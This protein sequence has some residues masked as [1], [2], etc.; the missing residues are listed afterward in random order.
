MDRP[1]KLTSAGIDAFLDH[2]TKISVFDKS[3]LYNVKDFLSSQGDI[4][5]SEENRLIQLNP[6]PN[7][8]FKFVDNYFPTY[9]TKEYA[10]NNLGV[11][12]S[13]GHA[14]FWSKEVSPTLAFL[15]G[16]YATGAGT[17]AL[18]L[19]SRAVQLGVNVN[20]TINNA[21]K[22]IDATISLQSNIGV[23][24]SAEDVTLNQ[25]NMAEVIN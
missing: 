10:E 5:I 23:I 3:A 4:W 22:I 12:E 18:K 24:I 20:R 13:L 16:A 19:G 25:I 7:H 17:A 11:L 1:S 14:E 2:D 6:F 8:T 9:M 15:A 21:D